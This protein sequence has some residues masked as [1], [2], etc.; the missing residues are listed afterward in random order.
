MA[1]HDRFHR[2][3]TDESAI[4]HSWAERER[5]KEHD[6][7]EADEESGQIGFLEMRDRDQGRESESSLP[8]PCRPA[9]S[10]TR[11]RSTG[12]ILVT[13]NVEQKV[14]REWA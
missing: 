9:K 12:G 5:P 13:S 2:T 10:L 8:R 14:E 7:F 6:K 4:L 3:P 11:S 1:F